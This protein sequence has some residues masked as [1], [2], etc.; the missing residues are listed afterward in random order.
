MKRTLF[1]LLVF[2]SSTTFA[3]TLTFEQVKNATNPKKELLKHYESYTA[4]DGYTYS[5][6]DKLTVGVPS[7]DIMCVYLFSELAIAL[8]GPLGVPA[9]FAE[10]QMEIT[11]IRLDRHKKRGTTVIMRCNLVGL[12]GVLV[13]FENALAAGEIVSEGMNRDKAIEELK[14]AKELL[15]LEVIT[16]QEFDS[17]KTECVKYIK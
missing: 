6:G 2:I 7:T 11:D 4:S 9:L 16:Q 10:N 14:K 13:K 15:E 3:Q 12:G 8:G 1:I 5:V 17:I